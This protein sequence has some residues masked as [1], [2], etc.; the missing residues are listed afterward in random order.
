M[1]L[2]MVG[3]ESGS[4]VTTTHSLVCDGACAAGALLPLRNF[5]CIPGI[6]KA[7]GQCVTRM[8]HERDDL[9]WGEIR[10]WICLDIF[11]L[12]ENPFVPCLLQHSQKHS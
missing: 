11:C 8:C 2:R 3:T 9:E 12:L 5:G 6:E 10:T 7:D 1:A 4:T